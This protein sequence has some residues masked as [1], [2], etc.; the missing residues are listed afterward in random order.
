MS[1]WPFF[2]IL[3]L[4]LNTPQLKTLRIILKNLAD[5][6]KSSDPKYRSIKLSKISAKFSPCPSAMEYLEAIGFQTIDK[7]GEETLKIDNVIV[8]HME[9]VMIELKNALEMVIPNCVVESSSSTTGEEKKLEY[10]CGSFSNVALPTGKMSEKQK[11]RILM[12]KKERE[13]REEAKR[14]RKK[15]EAQIKHGES[16]FTRCSVFLMVLP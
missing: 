9:A 16:L 8:S 11:A 1:T 3:H 5:P 14:A 12:E 10:E 15:T 2:H 6:V 13:D 4:H 7:D